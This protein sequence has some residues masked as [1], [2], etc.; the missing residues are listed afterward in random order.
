MQMVILLLARMNRAKVVELLAVPVTPRCPPRNYAWFTAIPFEHRAEQWGRG[1][2]GLVPVPG[3]C[4]ICISLR[5]HIYGVSYPMVTCLFRAAAFNYSALANADDA[6]GLF[7]YWI[8]VPERLWINC[9]DCDWLFRAA[10]VQI[11]M[12]AAT[13]A[14]SS[15]N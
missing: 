7:S 5:F 8:S 11:R 2:G 3:R 1:R 12:R 4:C 6:A 10:A 15:L 13:P 9:Y 14:R